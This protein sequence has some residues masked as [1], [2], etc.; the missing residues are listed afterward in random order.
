LA[1]TADGFWAVGRAGL[2]RFKGDAHTDSPLP[3]T[4]PFGGTPIGRGAGAIVVRT[5]ATSAQ[6]VSGFQMLVAGAEAPAP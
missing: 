1:A 4:A 2:Y 6:S 3:A 5:S